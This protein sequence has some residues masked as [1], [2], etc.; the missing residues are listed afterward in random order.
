MQ[1]LHRKNLWGTVMI[2]NF[3]FLFL[4]F[5]AVISFSAPSKELALLL[6]EEEQ[7]W[8][9]AHP[10]IRVS[11]E[12]DYPPFDF[13]EN[14]LAKGLSIEYMKLLEQHIGVTFEFVN[15]YTWNQLLQLARN[16]ELDL[17][18][19]IVKTEERSQYLNFAEP[20]Y[21]TPVVLVVHEEKKDI[22]SFDDLMGKRVAVIDDY[23]QE[24]IIREKYPQI[25]MVLVGNT[26]EALKAV[27]FGQADATLEVLG[28]VNYEIRNNFL[29]N[30]KIVGEVNNPD[31]GN[32]ILS[33]AVR[34]DWPIL[35]SIITKAQN[36]IPQEQLYPIWDR[37][38]S[39]D[40]DQQNEF[41]PKVELTLDE[42]E[43]LNDHPVIRYTGDPLW[44]PFESVSE[45]GRHIGIVADYLAL[46][47]KRLSVDFK[48]V[49]AADWSDAV[50]KVVTGEVDM[51]SAFT[52]NPSLQED[53][54]FTKPY[55]TNQIMIFMHEQD[56]FITS[57]LEIHD[58]SIVLIKGYGYVNEI[59]E[60][61][62]EISF[63][64]VNNVNEGL[65]QVSNGESDALLCSLAIGTYMID[66][67]GIHHVKVVG[68]TDITMNLGLGIRQDWEPLV[69]ILN[70]TIESISPE[71][72][73]QI[74][75]RWNKNKGII[76]RL[77]YTLLAQI[78]GVFLLILAVISVWS[79]RLKQ[80]VVLRRQVEE[81]LHEA[82]IAADAANKAKSDFL[83]SMSHEIRT[84]L[85][86]MVANL[87][88]LELTNVDEEQQKTIGS[89]K[90]C[91]DTL[92]AI[93]GDILDF[94]KIEAGKMDLD[95]H[96][97]D[98]ISTLKNVHSMILP[99]A[100]Q[101]D[102]HLHMFIAPN[103][104]GKVMADSI[105]IRQVIVNLVGNAIKFTEHGGV[106]IHAS[107]R[108][109]E[110]GKCWIR[111]DI[112]DSGVGFAP[113]KA[114][115]LF[116]AFS[117]EEQSTTR[118]FGGTGLGLAICKRI[119]EMN[120][121]EIG[122][123]GSPGYGAHFYC[124]LPLQVVQEAEPV[125]EE[126]L[127]GNNV[128]VIKEEGMD[129]SA[130]IDNLKSRNVNVHVLKLDDI[131]DQH[132]KLTTPFG[133]DRDCIVAVTPRPE[134]AV[135]HPLINANRPRRW[136]LVSN[137]ESSNREHIAI[138]QGFSY[139]QFGEPN[140]D[141][142]YQFILNVGT[143]S[144]GMASK[145]TLAGSLAGTIE[146]IKHKR[147]QKPI[148]V[149]DDFEMNRNV[150]AKQ[151]K[152]FGLICETAVNGKDGLDKAKEYDYALIFCDWMMPVMDGIEFANQYRRWEKEQGKHIPV[153]AMTANA[154]KGDEERCRKA[155]MDD[156]LSKPV[157]LERLGEILSK[158]LMDEEVQLDPNE[159]AS[160]AVETA[161]LQG[162]P[163]VDLKYLSEILGEDDP[164]E[165]AETLDMY[166]D[167]LGN[168]IECISIAVNNQ[169]RQA[170]RDA[171][172]KA[173]GGAGYAAA[174]TLSE[175]Y[176]D[177]QLS[178]F[179]ASWE[180]LQDKLNAAN[181]EWANVKAYIESLIQT[182][183]AS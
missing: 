169:D 180:E 98:L 38:I 171:S 36:I 172:H 161:P 95:I 65:Q 49:P 94:S 21:D 58:K 35:H 90:F 55:I 24:N 136:L 19:S 142:V 20:Y 135:W 96:E 101:K 123:S 4:L 66:E 128:I 183:E 131:K 170:Y 43:W 178:A 113:D 42:Q 124:E 117:Q 167:E 175:I 33:V 127:E 2:K 13:S 50:N 111:F 143:Q 7:A 133:Q 146:S 97:M 112:V 130:L 125:K 29:T 147:I 22:K 81:E 30:V 105:R 118:K 53:F 79:W 27:S 16:K 84:P 99:R 75:D 151:L 156:Y 177:M 39:Y 34:D 32:M 179:D 76:E 59:K 46:F 155:G 69:Q 157:K 119:A 48:Y 110:E 137:S 9:L 159:I 54:N 41:V 148:L 86:G 103:V 145:E 61:F 14:G 57:L 8:L 40:P 104:P 109:D 18:Q 70:K 5:S 121:G 152:T 106:I 71:E 114:A 15:G 166:K 26:A 91:A 73:H 89:A 107:R 93:I 92:L 144:V 149:I 141:E 82:R 168:L 60:K 67:L 102:I 154:L 150:A 28:V 63:T 64:E 165:L 115:K 62:P 23:Y 182:V 68:K 80:E 56:D 173:K 158:W 3:L 160:M 12:E 10:I 176:K 52:T 74:L 72:R 163:P 116:E 45:D 132:L 164:V 129:A 85:N 51:I 140:W 153:I 47:Q 1:S 17:M 6:T 87:E 162:T 134:H 181:Q 174:M 100:V 44:M 138:R 120:D 31:F 108:D 139:Y 11:N 77:D 78:I 25:E 126:W 88:L 83:A 37:W 122:C